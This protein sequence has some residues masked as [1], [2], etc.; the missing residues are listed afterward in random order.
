VEV[1][2]FIP[3]RPVGRKNRTRMNM[4]NEKIEA[5]VAVTNWAATDSTMPRIRPPR[6]QPGM[7][8]IPPRT[9]VINERTPKANPMDGL[10]G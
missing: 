3:Q 2:L 6:I 4:T 5:E 9:T 8:P 7:L 1:V 10:T